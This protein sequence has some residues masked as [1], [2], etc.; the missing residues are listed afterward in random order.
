VRGVD[1]RVR[2]SARARSTIGT[3]TAWRSAPVAAVC[4][5]PASGAHSTSRKKR[6]C[7]L[8]ARG[9]GRPFKRKLLVGQA[10]W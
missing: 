9:S 10:D 5:R 1:R 6:P 7:A 3:A 2:L 8:S 4:G